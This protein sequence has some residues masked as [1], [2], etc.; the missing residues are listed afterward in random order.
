MVLTSEQQNKHLK[1]DTT[2]KTSPKK[3]QQEETC[4]NKLFQF[5]PSNGD[6]YRYK[7]LSTSLRYK[8]LLQYF[9]RFKQMVQPHSTEH[10][11]KQQKTLVKHQ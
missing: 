4:I 3:I 10:Y 11:V 5:K 7:L 9:Q 6:M 2:N 8:R 1:N